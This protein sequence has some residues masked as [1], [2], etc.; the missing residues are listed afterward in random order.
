MWTIIT[1][2]SVK[3]KVAESQEHRENTGDSWE[4]RRDASQFGDTRE[5]SAFIVT[6]QRSSTMT[7]LLI[8]SKLKS[9]R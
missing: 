1:S 7:M 8:P 9:K 2:C 4:G 6:R 3:Q 5:F